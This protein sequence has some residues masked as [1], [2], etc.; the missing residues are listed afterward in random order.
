MK[1][2]NSVVMTL[3]CALLVFSLAGCGQT[4]PLYF[5]DEIPKSQRAKK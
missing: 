4:G 3:L 2:L 5:P 1:K